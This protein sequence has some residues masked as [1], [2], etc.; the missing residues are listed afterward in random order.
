MIFK[1]LAHSLASAAISGEVLGDGFHP[2]Q[3]RCRATSKLSHT[4]GELQVM[5]PP[6][7]HRCRSLLTPGVIAQA[8]APLCT[9][10]LCLAVGPKWNGLVRNPGASCDQVS[11]RDYSLNSFF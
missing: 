4:I 10:L 5:P 8:T 11:K 3:L 9:S 7:Q 1:V 6:V 2:E